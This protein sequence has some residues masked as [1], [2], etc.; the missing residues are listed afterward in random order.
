MVFQRTICQPH[1]KRAV[2]TVSLLIV[3]LSSASAEIAL[4]GKERCRRGFS[5]HG[6]QNDSK[7]GLGAERGPRLS[8]EGELLQSEFKRGAMRYPIVSLCAGIV[9]ADGAARC[10]QSTII[11]RTS[12]YAAGSCLAWTACSQTSSSWLRI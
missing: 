4:M 7:P 9:D 3:K 5:L 1:L 6:R 10:L 11:R 12:S 8:L 2:L